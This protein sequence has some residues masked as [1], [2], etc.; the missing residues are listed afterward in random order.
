LP[1]REAADQLYDHLL[2]MHDEAFEAGRFDLS[3]HLL[4]AALH[5]AEEMEDFARLTAIQ[6]T[7]EQRQ[8]TLDDRKPAHHMST[9]SAR[10]RGNTAAQYTALSSIAGAVKG[11]MA[12]HHAVGRGQ[13][14]MKKGAL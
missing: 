11:R 5:A 12:A 13:Q 14:F 1:N 3:Y 2:Q 9:A 6:V 8:Q 10:E 4:A 7:A